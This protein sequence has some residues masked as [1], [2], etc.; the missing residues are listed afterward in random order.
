MRRAASRA[1]CT[2]GNNKATRMPMMAMTTNNSTRVNAERWG[3]IRPRPEG[4]EKSLAA[5][6]N[7][8][9]EEGRGFGAEMNSAGIITDLEKSVNYY[10]CAQAPVV[11]RHQGA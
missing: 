6:P 10:A 9:N 8:P 7:G 1:D 5:S 3:R 11:I 2:A 4:A